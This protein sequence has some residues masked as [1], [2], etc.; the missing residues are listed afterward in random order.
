MG[1]GSACP[2]RN[3]AADASN[4]LQPGVKF[5]EQYPHP[6][7]SRRV[8]KN[9]NVNREV[10]ASASASASAVSSA[11]AEIETTISAQNLLNASATG[12]STNNLIICVEK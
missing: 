4:R 11:D 6:G 8:D 5:Q 2:L 7:S 3:L 9:T 1:R 10:F 12:P